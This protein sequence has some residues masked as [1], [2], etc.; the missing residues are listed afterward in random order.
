MTEAATQP[1]VVSVVNVRKYFGP[2]RAL[3]GCSFSARAGEIHA[4]IGGNGCGKSTLAKVIS[5]VLPIDGGSVSILGEAPSTPA[6]S[7]ATGIATVYQE[8]LVAEES[9]VVDNLYMGVDNLF[10]ASV[11]FDQ[12]VRGAIAIMQELAGQPVDP[13]ANVGTL[14]L[15]IKQWITIGRALMS[16]P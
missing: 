10:S 4:I 16:R 12:K 1:V 14:P 8:V 5:G 6:E 2:T 7:R 13:F 9:S 11:P 3:D 15:A